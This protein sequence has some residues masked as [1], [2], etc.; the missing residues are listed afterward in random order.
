METLCLHCLPKER[1]SP[2]ILG[3]VPPSAVLLNANVNK[4]ESQTMKAEFIS[5]WLSWI[6][7][8]LS[9]R[10]TRAPFKSG[11]HRR[12]LK[13]YNLQQKYSADCE[14]GNKVAQRGNPCGPFIVEIFNATVIGATEN[15]RKY[16]MNSCF[17]YLSCKLKFYYKSVSRNTGL[18]PLCRQP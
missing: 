7:T 9:S 16:H 12:C 5:N 2:S 13:G 14:F 8:L 15:K 3:K 1:G 4:K 17:F 10:F 6:L 11:L 18:A